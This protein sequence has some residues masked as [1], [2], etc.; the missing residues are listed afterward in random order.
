METQ[1]NSILKQVGDKLLQIAFSVIGGLYVAF[2]ASTLYW[3]LCFLIILIDVLSAYRLGRRLHRKYPTR[4]D[5][6]FK[7]EYKNR[8]LFTILIVLLAIMA[9]Y[10]VDTIV[11]K[12]G[13]NISQ[14]SV[15]FIFIFYE[16]WS[17]LENS[18]SE[19]DNPVAK[20]LQR[21]MVNKA[22]RHF[23][24]PLQEIIE[25]VRKEQKERIENENEKRDNNK[26]Q[27]LL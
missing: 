13:T 12:D 6:K 26:T 9:G 24:I 1:L 18:S 3:G 22:E 23:N 16:G 17:V 2:E 14:K 20:I 25:D 19:S 11:I 21:V 4:C 10:M 7:S 27:N 5:G 8:I 15:M